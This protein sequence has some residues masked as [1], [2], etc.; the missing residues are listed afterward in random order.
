M[1]PSGSTSHAPATPVWW[2]ESLPPADDLWGV[3]W[4]FTRRAVDHFPGEGGMAG[5]NLGD[6]VGDDAGR[7]AAHRR[8]LAR[9]LGVGLDDLHWMNQ[10]HG[11]SVRVVDA[12]S[13]S[14]TPAGSHV[15][16]ESDGLVVDAAERHAAGL[17]PGAGLVVVADCTPTL[18]VERERGLC[19]VVHAG[20]PGMLA[21]V[22]ER[23]VQELRARGAQRLEAVVGPSVCSRCYEVPAEMRDDAERREPVSVGRTSWGTPSIDVAAGV[24]EQLSRLGVSLREWV[25]G[26]TL[27]EEDLFSYRRDGSTGRLAGAVRLVP[28]TSGGLS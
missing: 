17:E 6:H 8:A 12:E 7:V 21:G 1:T 20:R 22:V 24:V 3:E 27:E 9:G 5:F 26:C 11:A 2:Q 16:P 14:H 18:L 19:A 15:L 23:T 10:V 4:L 28:P 25:R 13:A